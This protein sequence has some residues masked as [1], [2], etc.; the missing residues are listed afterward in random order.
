MTQR[1]KFLLNYYPN[2][3]YSGG[4]FVA[5]ATI[6]LFQYNQDAYKQNWRERSKTKHNK[7]NLV[8]L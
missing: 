1:F 6:F 4:D 5:S 7:N 2:G 3:Y 8:L